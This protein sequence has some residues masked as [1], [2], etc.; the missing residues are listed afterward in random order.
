M[1]LPLGQRRLIAVILAVFCAAV[2][3]PVRAQA[4]AGDDM[5]QV[6]SGNHAQFARLV[7]VF[8]DRRAWSLIP[9]ETG[10]R[11][12]IER[13]AGYGLSGVFDL[14]PKDRI[15]AIVQQADG[16]VEIEVACQC[17]ADAI[18]LPGRGLVLDIRDGPAPPGN[19]FELL[20]AAPADAADTPLEAEPSSPPPAWT[21]PTAAALRYDPGL[22]RQ[23]D[24]LAVWP[25]GEPS[26]RAVGVAEGRP[27]RDDASQLRPDPPQPADG[28]PDLVATVSEGDTVPAGTARD[29]AP[30]GPVAGQDVVPGF[31]AGST[32][33]DDRAPAPP[34]RVPDGG[35][36]PRADASTMA[37]QAP[38]PDA[39]LLDGR[40]AT[41]AAISEDDSAG[42]VPVAALQPPPER[43]GRVGAPAVVRSADPVSRPGRWIEAPTRIRP[44]RNDPVREDGDPQEATTGP[45]PLPP[46]MPIPPRDDL[47]RML[48]LH[49][50][51][52]R[53]LPD[54][55]AQEFAA[56]FGTLLA[57][58]VGRG[59]TQG[60][61][62]PNRD[63]LRARTA[64][65]P[66]ETGS[67]SAGRDQGAAET[68]VA[69]ADPPASDPVQNLTPDPADQIRIATALDRLA[70]ESGSTAG[71]QRGT[72]LC[73]PDAAVDV[74]KW[75][76]EAETRPDFGPSR[77][78]L[79]GEFD[80]VSDEA[81]EAAVRYQIAYGFG[82]EA[83]QL[84]DS[85]L[86]VS[87]LP[88]DRARVLRAMSH[89]V[90]GETGTATDALAGQLGCPSPASLWGALAHARLPPDADYS[91]EAVLKAFEE[92]PTGLRRSL[93]P[94]LAT[95]FLE[96]G[97]METVAALRRSF[98]RID[99][100]SDAT[101]EIAREAG[102]LL[103]A[104]V[105]ATVGDPAAAEA[106]LA[107]VARLDGPL[108]SEATAELVESILARGDVPGDPLIASAAALAFEFRGTDVG[109][110]LRRGEILSLVARE[111]Y[112]S[113]LA[114]L[115]RTV[116]RADV[117]SDTVAEI[118]TRYVEVLTTRATD[119]AF[120]SRAPG[121]LPFLL[122]SG[123]APN[124]RIAAA[125]RLTDLGLPEAALPLVENLR[126]DPAA[127]VSAARAWLRL[128]DPAAA[129]TRLAGLDGDAATRLRAEAYSALGDLAAAA[130]ALD[131]IG[132]TGA[133]SDAAW[134]AGDMARVADD[135]EATRSALAGL[136][137][138][139]PLRA[140]AT[141]ESLAEHQQLIEGTT[142]LRET[143]AA[144]LAREVG[145]DAE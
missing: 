128:S 5:I 67:D 72:P 120:L 101:S 130:D 83:R 90:D 123:A 51:E 52:P 141:T 126:R 54:P 134:R 15:A 139:D 45:V 28:P 103:D 65:Q 10:Y 144:E 133:A 91:R 36:V 127:R 94:Q 4:Q 22:P 70:A 49:P 107:G 42:Q 64:A 75:I 38:G 119:R 43:P 19:P 63:T 56:A 112:G 95:R 124:A 88:D 142:R 110:R 50:A 84:L 21:M 145:R 26:R 30:V 55:R 31:E 3:P 6:R 111:D 76:P 82:A 53:A 2:A 132:E 143:I 87:G 32:G 74:S 98:G 25:V 93:G 105:E 68:P 11:L 136:A 131:R 62:E 86:T 85:F 125:D 118:A 47:M 135:S 80:R 13:A 29:P 20:R 57:A 9:T 23:A 140:P 16:T 33:Q 99:M 122:E 89:I 116:D 71:A 115:R 12:R 117:A 137:L 39:L 138:G 7:F 102:T 37:A 121:D 48:P 81:L 8:P 69:E 60:V 34:A 92:L 73:L 113:A 100:P 106:R 129:L 108:A 114:E 18:D 78:T 14:I 104:R 61:V 79:L 35:A 96:I 109:Q 77:A 46:V 1:I 41:A 59:L 24:P 17:H 58:E 97:D 40:P 66:A 27:D 44:D